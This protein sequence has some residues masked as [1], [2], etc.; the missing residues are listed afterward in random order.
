MKGFFVTGTDTGVGKTVVSA[1]LAASLRRSDDVCYWKPV[2]TGIEEDDDTAMV[3]E[4]ADCS[5]D[6][7]YS[8]GIRLERPLSPHLS[9][10]LAGVSIDIEGILVTAANHPRERLMIVEGAGGVLVPLNDKEMM[11]DLIRDLNLP[12][13]VVSRSGLGTINHTLMTLE[14]LRRR[15]INVAGVVMNG[16]RNDENRKAVEFYGEIPVIAEIPR[17][18]RLAADTLVPWAQ[19]NIEPI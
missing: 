9:A 17:F 12:A 13:I 8:E 3:A 4:L 2:Q 15:G 19:K 1:C 11:I 14:V 6:E 7:I 18:E 16:D 5:K 10:R